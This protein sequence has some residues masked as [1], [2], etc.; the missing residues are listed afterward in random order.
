MKKI[1]VLAVAVSAALSLTTA[2]AQ[3]ISI[4]PF[5]AGNYA[6]TDLG[7]VPQLPPLYGGLTFAPGDPNK[8]HIG[9]AANG[10]AG[11]IY[12]IGVV[13]GAGNHVI[14]FSGAAT[15][16][17]RFGSFN[18]GGV[19]YG[20]GGVLF[21]A[22]WPV[23]EIGQVKPGSSVE[24]KISNLGTN[25]SISALNFVPAG[26]G[27]AGKMKVVTY[28]GG[29]WYDVTYAPDGSGTF[30]L[31]ATRVDL[32]PGTPGDQDL[33]GGPEGFVYIAGGNPNF[34]S[35]SLLVA[36]YAAGRIAS[37]VLD[38]DGNPDLGTRRDF[39]TGLSGAEGATIDP[40]T[41]DF[42]F[43]TFGGGNKVVV[44]QGFNTPTTPGGG[45]QVPVPGTLL[46]G[47]AGLAAL[48]MTCRKIAMA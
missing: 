26:F 29:S 24:D 15:A 11:L 44:V 30:N 2:S 42:L 48:R 18:D 34:A 9:G 10:A 21:L 5:Y 43:S 46:L 3:A 16:L 25:S 12:E 28:G 13:R 17:G 20:P 32:D 35:D 19:V 47:L 1:R 31:A 33:G 39:L 37:Y 38:G 41:G 4:D 36:E 6:F 27:G 14:G 45:G 40:L 23:N 7:S 22:R 8:I